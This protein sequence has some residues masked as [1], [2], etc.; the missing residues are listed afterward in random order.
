MSC[1]PSMTEGWLN[2]MR[3]VGFRK[4]SPGA[5]RM[6]VRNWERVRNYSVASAA[7]LHLPS[8]GGAATHWFERSWKSLSLLLLTL[9]CTITITRQLFW[10]TESEPLIQTC[11]TGIWILIRPPG[12]CVQCKQQTLGQEGQFSQ[13]WAWAQEYSSRVVE[14]H[15]LNMAAS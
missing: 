10:D 13:L 6:N 8:P 1:H 3:Q 4:W 11:W 9:I 14:Y 2:V 7:W 12:I 5:Y 15:S